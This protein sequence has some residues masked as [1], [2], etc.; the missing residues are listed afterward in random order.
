MQNYNE[1]QISCNQIY[2]MAYQYYGVSAYPEL[3]GICS[4]TEGPPPGGSP[5][6]LSSK[7]RTLRY[8]RGPAI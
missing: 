5:E 4:M 3:S 8:V 1:F 7:R 6:D 2:G